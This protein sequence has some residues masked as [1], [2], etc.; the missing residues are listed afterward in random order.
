MP[1]QQPASQMEIAE[2]LNFT[3]PT[4]AVQFTK[5]IQLDCLSLLATESSDIAYQVMNIFIHLEQNNLSGKL[6]LQQNCTDQ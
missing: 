5:T 4:T 6:S 2:Q 3:R 1:A